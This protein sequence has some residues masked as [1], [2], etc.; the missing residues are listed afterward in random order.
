M[1]FEEALR[2]IGRF[3]EQNLGD[4]RVENDVKVF[5]VEGGLQEG[6]GRAESLPILDGGLEVREAQVISAVDVEDLVAPVVNWV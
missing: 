6:L 1:V 3:T 4:L 5:A 2:A